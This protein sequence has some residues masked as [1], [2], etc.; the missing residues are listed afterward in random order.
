MRRANMRVLTNEN[1]PK[2][3]VQALRNRGHDVLSTKE[4]LRGSRDELILDRAQAESRLVVTQDKDFGELA[5]RQGQRAEQG[6]ILFRFNGDDPDLELAR[7][8]EVIESRPDWTG[9]FAVA[10]EDRLRI[11]PLPKASNP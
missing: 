2:S 4:S 11:R 6:V 8:V 3:V 5:F 9:L 10:T 1:I 7:M